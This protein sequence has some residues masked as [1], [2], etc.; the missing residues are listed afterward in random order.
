MNIYS[1]DELAEKIELL[2]AL[3][4]PYLPWQHT[5]ARKDHE[6]L[7]GIFIKKGEIYFKRTCGVAYDDV[8]KM[9]RQSMDKFVYGLLNGDFYF[10]K[11]AEKFQKARFNEAQRQI[12]K[13]KY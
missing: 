11:I 4:N 6:D 3:L 5:T 10:Q 13:L 1:E 7:F 2:N 9:S 12:N 8:I